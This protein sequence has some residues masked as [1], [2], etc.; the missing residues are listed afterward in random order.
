MLGNIIISPIKKPVLLILKIT[1]MHCPTCQTVN[2][3]TD[4]RCF[5]CRTLLIE[6]AEER[7]DAFKAAS[8]YIDASLYRRIGGGVGLAIAYLFFHNQDQWLYWALG[9]GF[10]SGNV[11]GNY[12]ASRSSL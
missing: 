6:T 12:L 5:Q 2:T 10:I 3:A 8:N 7:S 9:V 11:I 4:V 1:N